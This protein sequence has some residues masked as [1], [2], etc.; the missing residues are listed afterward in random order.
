MP[1]EPTLF[2][3]LYLDEDVHK[4]VA[5]ALRLRYFDAVSVHETGTWGLTDA[6]QLA[7][8]ADQQRALFTFNTMDFLRLHR[9]WLAT[10][11][12]HWGIIVCEQLPPGETIRRLLH[13]LNR[14]TADEMRNQVYWLPGLI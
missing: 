14:V 3:R 9:A 7:L 8:A 12:I 10:G 2:A 5:A 11:R 13:L 4:G 6:E 1:E